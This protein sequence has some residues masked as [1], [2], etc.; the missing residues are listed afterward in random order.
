MKKSLP[1]IIS[2]ACLLGSCDFNLS[3]INF[4]N[5]P[6]N[7]TNNTEGNKDNDDNTGTGDNTQ[8]KTDDDSG[9]TGK[10]VTGGDYTSTWPTDYQKYV[11]T[12]LNGMVPCFLNANKKCLFTSFDTGCIDGSSIPYFN[13]YTKNTS[14]GINYEHDYGVILSDAGFT[15]DGHE[16]D[17]EG[18]DVY[19]FHKGY[20][21]VNYSKYRGD[22]NIYYFD[23][24]AYYDYT[25]PLELPNS[26]LSLDVENM[27]LTGKYQSNYSLTVGSYTLSGVDIM[28]NS[29]DIQLKAN[30]GKLTI[31]G[32]S[33]GVAFIVS[34][35][36][37]QLFVRYGSS[38]SNLKYAFNEGGTFN[39]P[40]Q[41]SYIEITSG[42]KVLDVE[43]IDVL[44]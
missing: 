25:A 30:T 6:T 8:G 11:I 19:Y 10:P 40:S 20:C 41:A 29:Y 32:P 35:N 12:Y 18:K 38:S 2:L 16:I 24:Y 27:K 33:K 42:T 7:E 5:K 22:D 23:V 28:K 39:F 13:P 14:P 43:T 1:L 21:N 3:F 31:Q 44:N 17:E 37:D 26:K 9:N 34:K 4:G 36:A 15:S